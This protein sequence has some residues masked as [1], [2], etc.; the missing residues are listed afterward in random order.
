MKTNNLF[1]NN[2]NNYIVQLMPNFIYKTVINNENNNN[3][4]LYCLK[5]YIYNLVF[6]NKFHFN[7]KMKTITE[8]SAVDYP[9]Y[10]NRFNLFYVFNLM[11]ANHNIIIKSW[12]SELDEIQS[13]SSLFAAANWS[14]RE[15]W[16]MFGIIFLN[17]PDLRRILTDYGFAGYPLRKDFPLSGYIELRYYDKYKRIIYS[18]I[19]LVQEYR[20][21]E[22]LS[23]WNYFDYNFKSIDK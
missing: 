22:L 8:L 17:H 23:P 20:N 11:N 4:Y 3:I 5:S 9:E 21:Y 10:S 14:E 16:D 13:V 1:Q 15:T 7:I 12:V 18:P 19:K 2:Y 6:I